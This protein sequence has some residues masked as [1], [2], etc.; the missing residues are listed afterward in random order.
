MGYHRYRHK[1]GG[2]YR[3]RGRSGRYYT[4]HGCY[5]ATCV[6]G[7]Y[8]CPEVW[9]LRRFRDY[10]LDN[11]YIGRLLINCYY[12]LSP[13]LVKRFGKYTWFKKSWR[14]ILDP[15]VFYLIKHGISNKKYNDKY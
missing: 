8:D 12:T 4:S 9:A 1:S 10:T 6:Y 13:Y 7:S 15:I 11:T 14:K 3:R 5:I 2:Y